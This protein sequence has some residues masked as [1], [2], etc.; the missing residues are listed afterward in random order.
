M[1]NTKEK[2]TVITVVLNDASNVEKTFFSVANQ[3]Y[4][5]IE[6]VII[7][8]GSVDETVDIIKDY[9][10]KNQER[11]ILFLSEKDDGIYDAMNKGIYLATGKYIVFMNCGDIFFDDTV[12][13]KFASEQHQDDFV[14]GN[15][16]L[17]KQDEKEIICKAE[18]E[19]ILKK[20]P[21]VHQ[22]CFVRATLQ[23][24]LKFDTS[25]R[26]SADYDFLLRAYKKGCTFKK[27][28]RFIAIHKT[29][30]ISNSSVFQVSIESLHALLNYDSMANIRETAYFADIII[31]EILEV[32][33][34]RFLSILIQNT[35]KLKSISW[36]RHPLKKAL[37]LLTLLRS[38]KNFHET[39]R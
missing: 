36:K 35:R 11:N 31:K 33:K 10:K 39:L 37:S 7:D 5:E 34:P 22:S 15:T 27:L 29:D 25:F 19:N 14:F 1:Q 3:S 20:M 38:F 17:R 2:I 21:F 13:E 9:I 28:D 12:I 8:G 16:I 32:N 23:K 26:I 24:R 4:S 30:G 6:H 18:I